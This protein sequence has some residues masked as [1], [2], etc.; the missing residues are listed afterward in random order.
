MNNIATILETKMALREALKTYDGDVK[1][2]KVKAK[3]EQLSQLNPI[4]KPTHS[5]LLESH[6]LL[7][8]APSFPQ[9]QNFLMANMLIPW[10]N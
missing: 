6:W 1:N 2:Q 8:S 10:V 5:S 9:G 7:I 3:I 4:E